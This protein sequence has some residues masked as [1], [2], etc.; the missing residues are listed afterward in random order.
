MKVTSL[1]IL[2]SYIIDRNLEINIFS[3]IDS[4]IWGFFKWYMK[5]LWGLFSHI[6]PNAK[7][8]SN[9]F[10]GHLS[11]CKEYIWGMYPPNIYLHPK[12]SDR[13]WTHTKCK[14]TSDTISWPVFIC[15]LVFLFGCNGYLSKP[16]SN[17]LKLFNSESDIGVL[18]DLK[19]RVAT[20]SILPSKRG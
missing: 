3:K 18:V 15:H 6:F 12:P 13:A 20:Y 5:S 9:I 14:S 1:I 8:A 17:L 2:T 16:L 11:V 7:V 10:W 19:L 4:K